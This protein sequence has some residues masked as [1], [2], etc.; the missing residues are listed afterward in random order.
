M[1]SQSSSVSKET[2]EAA[3]TRSKIRDLRP[4]SP[5]CLQTGSTLAE[6]IDSMRASKAG[7]VLVCEDGRVLGIITESDILH[8]VAGEEVSLDSALES[9]MTP[10]PKTAHLD[11]SIWDAIRSMDQGSY[12]HLPL[13]DQSGRVEGIISIQDIIEYLAAVFPTEVLNLP[14]NPQSKSR[15]LDGG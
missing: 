11:D 5:M 14:P 7:C 3:L 1:A 15:S 10:G 12:R 9:Y 6:A 2:A 4:A 13:V 8:K